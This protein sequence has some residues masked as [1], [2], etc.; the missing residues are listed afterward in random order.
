MFSRLNHHHAHQRGDS[1]PPPQGTW[2]HRSPDSTPSEHSEQSNPTQHV[3]QSTILPHTHRIINRGCT[4]STLLDDDPTTPPSQSPARPTL[5]EEP[6]S[7]A[8]PTLSSCSVAE[9]LQHLESLLDSVLAMV[10]ILNTTT[11]TPVYSVHMRDAVK[12]LST[13]FCP[14]ASVDTPN[15]PSAAE[16]SP[17]ICKSYNVRWQSRLPCC[18]VGDGKSWQLGKALG[19]LVVY[20][21]SCKVWHGALPEWT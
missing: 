4:D 21:L 17:Q 15:L 2:C 7:P 16:Q 13:L 12:A 5:A 10:V 6:T 9:H 11:T 20:S 19:P 3:P 18:H 14:K 8:A 1:E